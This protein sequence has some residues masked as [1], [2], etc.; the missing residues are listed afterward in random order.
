MAM[1]P[2]PRGTVVSVR[3]SAAE[4]DRVCAWILDLP[5]GVRMT[6]PRAVKALALAELDRRDRGLRH[7]HWRRT[8]VRV[9]GLRGVRHDR[10][11]HRVGPQQPSGGFDR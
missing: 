6:L 4:V 5:P 2:V 11:R 7:A 10:D 3:L 9:Q 8:D 1:A